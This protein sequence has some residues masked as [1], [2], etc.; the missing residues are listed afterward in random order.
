MDQEFDLNYISEYMSQITDF[1]FYINTVLEIKNDRNILFIAAVRDTIGHCFTERHIQEWQKT[2]FKEDLKEKHWRGYLAITDFRNL[3]YEQL[4]AENES[5]SFEAQIDPLTQIRVFSSP[6]S[7]LNTSEIII[8][9]EE[10]SDNFRGFNIV[11]YD[12]ETHTLIDTASFDTHT[13][14]GVR[15]SRDAI[16]PVAKVRERLKLKNLISITEET[17]QDYLEKIKKEHPKGTTSDQAKK[18]IEV[19]IIFYGFAA[20]WNSLRSLALAYLND[21]KYHVVIIVCYDTDGQAKK[22]QVV[23]DEGLEFKDARDYDIFFD[24][25]D[26]WITNAWNDLVFDHADFR[27]KEGLI[28][29]ISPDLINGGMPAEEVLDQYRLLSDVSDFVLV[30][31]T[32][33]HEMKNAGFNRNNIIPGS[34][35]QYDNIYEKINSDNDIYKATGQYQQWKKLEDKKVFLWATDHVWD[36]KNVTFDLYAKDVIQYFTEHPELGLIIRPHNMYPRELIYA[37]VWTPFD[38]E[39]IRKYFQSSPN[40]I[41]DESSDISLAYKASDA[42]ITDVNCGI[43][44]AGIALGKPLAILYRNDG[45][46]CIPKN[47]E[48]A[49][50]LY[51]LK[52][53]D[54]LKCFFEMVASGHEDETKKASREKLFEK[55]I[56]NFDGKNYLRIKDFIEKKYQIKKRRLNCRKGS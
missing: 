11:L 19:R 40:I 17:A 1:C 28:I 12:L 16:H 8:N 38:L 51:E 47:Q 23:A 52:N 33:Y 48:I 30:D 6:W 5:V 18:R 44:V 21:E 29:T 39:A 10:F 24:D 22:L 9:G 49:S 7:V 54:D 56:S 46:E 37:N 41:W 42:V 3:T 27:N 14:T 53:M 2:G 13:P 43:S 35:L 25:A 34:L 32:V 36:T 26:I 31:K 20:M 15:L 45:N 50:N 55:Y 4:G